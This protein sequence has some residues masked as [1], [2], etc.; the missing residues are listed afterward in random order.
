MIEGRL[1]STVSF[2]KLV[3]KEEFWKGNSHA[4]SAKIPV[5]GVSPQARERRLIC[6]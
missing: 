1:E 6:I 5:F 3:G 4:F 2:N